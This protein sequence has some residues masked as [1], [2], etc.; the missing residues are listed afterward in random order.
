MKRQYAIYTGDMKNIQ[1]ERNRFSSLLL[2]LSSLGF[3]AC[4][5]N[6]KRGEA[7]RIVAEWTGKTI[8]YQTDVQCSVMERVPSPVFVQYGSWGRISSLR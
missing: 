6:H 1:M 3:S 8:Q 4:N 5:E 2:V 7:R